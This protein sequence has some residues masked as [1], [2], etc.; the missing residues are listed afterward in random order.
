M[1][2]IFYKIIFIIKYYA[3]LRTILCS[4][5]CKHMYYVLCVL[6]L[7]VHDLKLHSRLITQPFFFFRIEDSL[8][9]K[10]ILVLEF[11]KC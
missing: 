3:G 10:S 9:K 8:E 7:F 5:T 2:L 11:N 1:L 6:C 4:F